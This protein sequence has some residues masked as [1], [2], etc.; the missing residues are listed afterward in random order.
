MVSGP[1]KV[2]FIGAGMM[3]IEHIKAFADIP[4]CQIVGIQS[5]TREKCENLS[6]AVQIP[7]IASSIAELY[8]KTR[9]D[10]VVITVNETSM[11]EVCVEAFKFP[12]KFLIEKPVGIDYDEAEYLAGLAAERNAAVW[13]ALNRRQHSSLRAVLGE[14]EHESGTRFI[15]IM[16][17]ENQIAARAYGHPELLVK[18]W[19]FANSIHMVDYFAM[20]GR[21]EIAQVIPVVPWDPEN[22]SLVI[23]KVTFSSGDV[24]LYQAIWNAP[25]PWTVS[26]STREKYFELRPLEQ[27]TVRTA[28]KRKAEP[29]P[30][31]QW[32]LDFKP[33]FRSQAEEAIKAVR[34][35]AHTL[36]NLETALG[37]MRLINAIYFGK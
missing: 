13:V 7:F 22:P 34:G 31:H 37:T 16:D 3:A 25:A 32:D 4:E 6:K 29:F 1:V 11:R 30:V 33:G 35:W 10:L 23:S 5:R 18:N 36:A 14:L 26:V 28:A 9:P 19:M 24:G 12:W 2:A 17:Q 21:G 8:E 27:A 15:H 20:L